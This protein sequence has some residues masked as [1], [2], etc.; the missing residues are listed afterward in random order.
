MKIPDA[1]LAKTASASS[2][3]QILIVKV[4]LKVSSAIY[5]VFLV[6]DCYDFI[7]SNYSRTFT[8]TVILNLNSST[9]R[10]SSTEALYW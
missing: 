4:V 9:A 10:T 3:L 8:S 2:C 7:R 6:N 5:V 1:Y